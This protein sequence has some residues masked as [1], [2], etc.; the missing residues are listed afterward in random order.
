PGAVYLS[1]YFI[2][3]TLFVFFTLGIVVAALFF[4]EERKPS[5]LI[6]GAVSAS[7]LFATK[8]TAFI[9][10]GVL[11]IALASTLIYVYL[12]RR[13]FA[14][15][16]G[17]PSRARSSRLQTVLNEMGG[18]PSVVVTVILAVL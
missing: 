2:H 10:V 4:Y 6:L 15:P 14:P 17:K 18:T 13:G 9:S 11:I 16:P 3:E 8:E 7:L 5:Y 1:R 12:Y